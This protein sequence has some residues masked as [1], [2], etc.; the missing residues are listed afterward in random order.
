MII[1]LFNTPIFLIFCNIPNKY[2][3]LF[4]CVWKK[5]PP[6][7]PA[8]IDTLHLLL[9]KVSM[10][11]SLPC[12]SHVFDL[13]SSRQAEGRSTNRSGLSAQLLQ[14]LFSA[15][16]SSPL[17]SSAEVI[18]LSSK[19]S[20]PALETLSYS[21]PQVITVALAIFFSSPSKFYFLVLQVRWSHQIARKKDLWLALCLYNVN[22]FK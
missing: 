4:F 14:G 18:L 5:C 8:Y 12:W 15:C 2:I 6:P 1:E 21:T 11:L 7:Q 20:T 9:K 22:Y 16:Q 19:L 13:C 3:S 17:I 10:Y